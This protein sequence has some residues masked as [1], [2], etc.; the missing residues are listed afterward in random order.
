MFFRIIETVSYKT[1][2]N[3]TEILLDEWGTSGRIR[4]TIGHLLY[5]LTRAE[6]FRAADYIAIN[7]LNQ[8]PP[9]RPKDGPAALI[10][11]ELPPKPQ[12]NEEIEQHLEQMTYSSSLLENINS[13]SFDTNINYSNN[14][15]TSY[16]TN[17]LVIPKIVISETPDAKSSSFSVS[18]IVPRNRQTDVSDSNNENVVSEEPQVPHLSFL[19]QNGESE[20]S[21]L[22]SSV[23]DTN[24]NSQTEDE[25]ATSVSDMIKFST[26]EN[27]EVLQNL[28]VLNVE[29]IHED[30][31]PCLPAFSEIF[32]D[33]GDENIPVLLDDSAQNDDACYIPALSA[34]HATTSDETSNFEDT[35]LD[36]T[37]KYYTTQNSN[38]TSNSPTLHLVS[39]NSTSRT[40]CVSPLPNL[41]LNTILK[42]FSYSELE[43]ATDNFDETPHKNPLEMEGSKEESGGRFLGSGAFGSVFLALG[44][45]PRPIAVKKLHLEN[46]DVVN[47]DDTVTKQFRN[48]VELLCKYTHENLLSLVGFSCDGP[49]YCLM[50]EY[51]SGGALKERLQVRL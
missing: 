12:K 31:A 36:S 24:T 9:E 2:R 18:L 45:L 35:R 44:L 11:T 10:T 23:S 49:T 22:A 41:S 16:K 38:K 8:Q 39:R 14:N 33:N 4:P 15:A 1:H 20:N 26:G 6:L 25:V 47:V 51:I 50:Y 5:L 28:S 17:K 40:T 13:N 7:L 34:L 37:L 48:E 46:V 43:A 30:N 29:D 21:V 32:H 42:H 19:M 27:A 3:C